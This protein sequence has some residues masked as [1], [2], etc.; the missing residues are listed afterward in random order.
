MNTASSEPELLASLT[1][2][3]YAGF[4]KIT[5]AFIAA[6]FTVIFLS[7]YLYSVSPGRMCGHSVQEECVSFP[8]SLHFDQE[9]TS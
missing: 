7:L 3:H 1:Y 8:L 6:A 9:N 5:V 4:M 2:R